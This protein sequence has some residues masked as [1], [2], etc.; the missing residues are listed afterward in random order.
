MNLKRTYADANEEFVEV[1]GT[2]T[3]GV[4][5]LREGAGFVT[6][7]ADLDFT[8]TRVELLGVDL[9]VAVEG[10][11]VSESSSKTSDGFSTTRFD[12]LSYSFKNYLHGNISFSKQKPLLTGKG[13]SS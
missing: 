8:E 7:D 2:I 10:I 3:I 5:E 11:E 12:L 4:E 1:D 9:V 6:A 13:A